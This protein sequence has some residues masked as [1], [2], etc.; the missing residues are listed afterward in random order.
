MRTDSSSIIMDFVLAAAAAAL[1]EFSIASSPALN[2]YESFC[3]L[4]LSV[5]NDE[6]PTLP[7][8]LP[9]TY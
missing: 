3:L 2:I 9:L 7:N 1:Y 8:I 6:A 5:V 4:L